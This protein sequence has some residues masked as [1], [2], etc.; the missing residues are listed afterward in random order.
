[1]YHDL[2]LFLVSNYLACKRKEEPTPVTSKQASAPKKPRLVFTDL[3]RRTLQAI[4]KETKRP[5]KEM[6]I[7]ISQQ[8]GLDLSTVG[9]FFMNARRRSQDKWM[10]DASDIS[11]HSSPLNSASNSPASSASHHIGGPSGSSSSRGGGGGGNS[12]THGNNNNSV[13]IKGTSL[14]GQPTSVV[15]LGVVTSTTSSCT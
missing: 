14:S 8:L 5:S 11:K 9:N 6:Q 3:Q 13:V 12:P 15:T 7:T 4:F 1:M 10:D 2:L